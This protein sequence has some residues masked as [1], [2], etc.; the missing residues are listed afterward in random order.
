MAQRRKNIFVSFRGPSERDDASDPGKQLEDNTT[1]G[2]LHLV[3]LGDDE[4][5]QAILDAITEN[6]EIHS[7]VLDTVTPDNVTT[8]TQVQIQDIETAGRTL[9]LV[10]VSGTGHDPLDDE[11]YEPTD[12][13]PQESEKRVDGVI[14]VDDQYTIVQE[15]K[16]QGGEL[17]LNEMGDYKS[18]LEVEDRN[19]GTVSWDSI[20]DNIESILAKLD[21]R[22][23]EPTNRSDFLA[24]Q[25][26]QYLEIHG[27]KLSES[28]SRYSSGQ[29][30]ISLRFQPDMKVVTPA[31]ESS[32]PEYAA[33][34]HSLP[35][36]DGINDFHISQGELEALLE[37]LEARHPGLRSALQEGDFDPFDDFAN[38]HNMT[39][40]DTK[41][42][43]EIGD[44]KAGRKR[45][46][47]AQPRDRD[48]R[49]L[50]FRRASPGSS[51]YSAGA[52]YML[53]AEEFESH[54]SSR[55]SEGASTI[56]QALFGENPDIMNLQ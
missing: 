20:H 21:T 49:V 29:K 54:F 24:S 12:E 25:F 35:E 6:L 18:L 46:Q 2:Q 52:Y 9:A 1:K 37:N 22:D 38:N 50:G 42:I 36:N 45:L 41:I 43:A 19:Y 48:Y 34:F 53:A 26:T 56:G 13:S 47:V 33:H 32:N 30:Y 14:Y 17:G 28:E 39:E 55:D 31:A 27:L 23:D 51:Q 3:D 11:K 15:S 44:Q 4:L 10:G 16:F 7:D 5:I 40:G 8:K